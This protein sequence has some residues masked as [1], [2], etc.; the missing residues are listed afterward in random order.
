MN[1]NIICDQMLFHLVQT[2]IR[3]TMAK[4]VDNFNCVIGAMCDNTQC[5]APGHRQVSVSMLQCFGSSVYIN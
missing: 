4:V 3:A 2:D 1:W 5:I